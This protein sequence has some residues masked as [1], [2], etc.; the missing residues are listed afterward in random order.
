MTIKALLGHA[1]IGVTSGYIITGDSLVLAA[2][3]KVAHHIY[4]AMNE[5]MGKVIGL[6]KHKTSNL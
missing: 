2:A 6:P 3:E 5:Q 4:S 1:R